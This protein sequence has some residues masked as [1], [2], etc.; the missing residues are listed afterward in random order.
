M[1]LGRSIIL[2]GMGPH[3][4]VFSQEILNQWVKKKRERKF[5]WVEWLL[6]EF[7]EGAE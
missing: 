6:E 4:N 1:N 3:S 5:G 7:G 2:Q